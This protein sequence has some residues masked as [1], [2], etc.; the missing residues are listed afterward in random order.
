MNAI[1]A[2]SQ[3]SYDPDGEDEALVCVV[4]EHFKPL[5]SEGQSPPCLWLCHARQIAS[6][7]AKSTLS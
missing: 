6:E 2:L 4:D 7:Q 5:F 3:L 1:H